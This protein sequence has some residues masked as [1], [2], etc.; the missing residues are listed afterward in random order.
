MKI[1]RIV[2]LAIA[3]MLVASSAFAHRVYIEPQ[4]KADK[5][6]QSPESDDFSFANPMVL[7]NIWGSKSIFGYL[8]QGDVDVYQFSVTPGGP[9]FPFK[10]LIAMALTPACNQTKNNYVNIALVG[11]GLPEPTRELPFDIPVGYGVI[12]KENPVVEGGVERAIFNEPNSNIA[13]FL[14]EGMTEACIK[15]KTNPVPLATCDL[16]N[17]FAQPV[18]APYTP[19]Y[20]VVWDDGGNKQDYTLGIGVVEK[21]YVYQTPDEP[22]VYNNA[23]LHTPC[24]TPYPGNCA[25][26]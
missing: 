5:P 18:F 19:H 3:A 1:S 16:T 23:H 17:T 11:P 9:V 15:D 21:G 14:P 13:W 8:T 25:A 7:D 2:T 26:E 24:I 10:M 6:W 20:L 4:A 12:V 22:L